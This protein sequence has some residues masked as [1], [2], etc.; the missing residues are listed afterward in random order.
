[1]LLFAV[2]VF[3]STT[4][5][6]S[7]LSFEVVWEKPQGGVIDAKFSPD[8]KFVY[9]AIGATVKKLDVAN[10]E[11]VATFNNGGLTEGI[12]Y[13]EI[14][15][16]GKKLLTCQPGG[17]Y[18]W[19]TE[20]LI[21]ERRITS[22]VLVDGKSFYLSSF[23]PDNRH[24]LLTLY[25]GYPH[26]KL[27]T[28]E[29]LLFDLLENKVIKKVPYERIEQL[30]YSKDGKYFITGTKYED[31]PKVTL[32]DANT[33]KPIRDYEVPEGNDNGFR[34]IQI[35]DNNKL[36][37]VRTD[38]YHV[39]I[40]ETESGN[41]IKTNDVGTSGFNFELLMNDYYLIYQYGSVNNG[42]SAYKYPDIFQSNLDLLTG[43]FVTAKENINGNNIII[44]LFNADAL[45]M[46]LLKSSTSS[47][48]D[49]KNHY[50]TITVESERISINFDNADSIKII[51]MNGKILLDQKVNEP[52]ITIPNTFIPG[53]YI[54]LIKSGYR[55]YSQKFQVVR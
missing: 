31:I 2:V 33:L 15:P 54:C 29:I 13:L 30:H 40:I 49:P 32:W 17:V 47:I 24:I 39:K 19:D 9:C 7:Q 44:S 20:K 26:P 46:T 5:L 55:E 4:N 51:D 22:D 6:F 43:A 52:I 23:S 21:M 48:I 34:K 41:I 14:S 11:F 28:N 25:T 1:M 37:G 3:I 36:I 42:I 10:G 50:F 18:L 12:L 53:T 27:P 45:S 38:T 8:G 16:D 35:S